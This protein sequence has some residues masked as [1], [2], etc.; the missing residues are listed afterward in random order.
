MSNINNTLEHVRE[1][2]ETAPAAFAQKCEERYRSIIDTVAQRINETPVREIVMLAGPSSAGKTTTA[3]RLKDAVEALG[4]HCYTVSLDDFYKNRT[5]SPRL[6]DGSPDYETV[7]ALDLPFLSKTLSD[8]VTKGEAMMPE[9]DFVAG[10]RCEKLHRLTVRQGDVIVVEG[11]HALNPIV[12]EGLPKDRL[13][14]IYINVST[15]IYDA[16]DNIVLNKRNM[17]F[18]RRLIRDYRFR[19]SSPEN[20][21]ELWKTVC[22]GEDM[23]LFPYR[24][25]ADIKINTI[26][27]Y[28]TCVFKEQALPLLKQIGKDSAYYEDAV[29]LIRSIEKFPA[30]DASLVPADS[31]LREFLGKA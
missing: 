8:L 10:A 11:L 29:R 21:Y 23:Y 20:T 7:Q 22:R 31:L 15:R 3:K 2:A 1:M 28:E 30:M 24:E 19:G 26:H 25:N 13:F 17:R 14:K 27:L 16:K 4:M 18:I 12:T 5:E 9:F 6:P